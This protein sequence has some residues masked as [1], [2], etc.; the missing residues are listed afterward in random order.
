MVVDENGEQTMKKKVRQELLGLCQGI[1]SIENILKVTTDKK[2]KFEILEM[3]QNAIITLGNVL[4]RNGNTRLIPSLEEYCENIYQESVTLEKDEDASGYGVTRQKMLGQIRE[5]IEEFPCD[6]EVV[7]LPY[8][9]S[10][11]DC[12]ESVWEAFTHQDNCSVHVVPIPYYEFDRVDQQAKLCYEGH[13]FPEYVSIEHYEQY[14]LQELQ[15]D[16]AFVHNPY[17]NC[18]LVTSV[19]PEYY[20]ENL[21]QYVKKLVYIPY[22]LTGGTEPDTHANLPVYKHMDY[23]ITQSDV[24]TDRY[25]E[26]GVDR[27]KILALGSPKLDA[28]RRAMEQ[29][30]TPEEWKKKI[31]GRPVYFL[32]TSITGMLEKDIR[33]LEKT[34][35]VIDIFRKRSDCVLLWR[36]HPLLMTTMRAMR[37]ALQQKFENLK[38]LSKEE[39]IIVDETADVSRAVAI[40]CAYIGE[41]TSSIVHLFGAMG[42]P[43]FL[44]NMEEIEENFYDKTVEFIGGMLE[45]NT[46]WFSDCGNNALCKMNFETGETD[47]VNVFNG[48][49]KKGQRLYNSPCK[50]DEDT[51]FWA[52]LW[53][54]QEAVYHIKDNVVEKNNIG[55]TEEAEQATHFIGAVRVNDCIYMIPTRYPAILK[56]DVADKRYTRLTQWKQMMVLEEDTTAFMDYEVV[57][58]R[59][60]YIPCR[61]ENTILMLD[62]FSDEFLKYSV[63]GVQEGFRAITYDGRNFWLEPTSG[64]EII[65]WNPQK[66]MVVRIDAYSEEYKVVEGFWNIVCGK[67]Y[68][69]MIPRTAPGVLRVSRETYVVEPINLYEDGVDCASRK[70][71]TYNW[72]NHFYCAQNISETCFMAMRAYDGKIVLFDDATG[73]KRYIEPYIS[74]F[75]LLPAFDKEGDNLPYIL[76]EG[77]LVVIRQLIGRNYRDVNYD[78]KEALRRYGEIVANIEEQVGETIVQA[79]I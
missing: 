71:E 15:P 63:D 75:T 76:R 46:F 66:G 51:L 6:L 36:P 10:M 39:N 21:K 40:S 29:D 8:K 68:M 20:S 2:N 9:A 50:I 12:M 3:C 74:K 44:L 34:E 11:W 1:S 67:Q 59:Y 43:V 56:Y 33:A 38:V 79:I 69:Y 13:L 45:G 31:A 35:E 22:Y 47:I 16:I 72:P 53:G 70:A 32:N 73:Q 61:F 28:V 57:E 65:V 4:E 49:Y 26:L 77:A 54:Q 19:A 42:K 78:V 60:I 41:D 58:E 27:H 5:A 62:T 14:R 7:F 18:N 52:P 30:R 48:E 37:P 23:I 64:R 17:D 25:V 24:M 55:A